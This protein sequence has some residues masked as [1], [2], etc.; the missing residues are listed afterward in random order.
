MEEVDEALDRVYGMLAPLPPTDE[1]VEELR[2]ARSGP[3]SLADER[4]PVPKVD[5]GWVRADLYER[6]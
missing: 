1:L 6:G 4:I 3:Q 5:R 2:G